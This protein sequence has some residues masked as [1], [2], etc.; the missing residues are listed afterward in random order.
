MPASGPTR[1][2]P[3]AC[4][5]A[6]SLPTI[7]PGSCGC[8]GAIFSPRTG[9]AR[10]RPTAPHTIR[11][12]AAASW[13]ATGATTKG[14][15][16]AG[17]SDRSA[18]LNIASPATPWRRWPC[19]SRCATQWRTRRWAPSAR[20]SM[21]IRL[22]IPAALPRTPGP[23]PVRWM[24]GVCSRRRSR[25][26]RARIG[27]NSKDAGGKPTTMPQ[28][29]DAEERRIEENRN[30]AKNWRRWGPY[31]SE[32]QWGTVRED[33]SPGG[34][35]WDYLTHDQARSRA[36]RW[37]EDGI[38]GFSDD[39]QLMCLSIALWN[40]RDPILKERLFGL[41]NAQ[42]NHGEDVKEL[43][44][45]LD[46]TPTHSYMRMLYKYPQAAFPYARLVE[47]NRRWGR[48]EPEFELIDTGAF[49]DNRYFDV[50]IEYAK[51][52]VEDSLM[53]VTVH[54]RAAEAAALHVLPQLWA[55]KPGRGS[56]I[57]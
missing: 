14:R 55:R 6:H 21:E 40:G 34:T 38:A 56:P 18:S 53:Q 13:N 15:F 25:P 27:S 48:D 4:R 31:L 46:G 39:R 57:R 7:R 42:G 17:F 16:G 28:A 8:A 37:G 22:T 50:E 3:S 47:E 52:D 51:A 5:T 9:C 33:Y 19:W 26:S 49:D 1:S 45:Y 54:N 43:Y 32:R 41:T 11:T 29:V 30:G 20:F 23:S 36:Y 35:A 10:W 2:W 12:T 44:Y 24:R